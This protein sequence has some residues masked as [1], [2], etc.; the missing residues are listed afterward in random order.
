MYVACPKCDWRPEPV[1]RWECSCGYVW[2]T[3]ETGGICPVCACHWE[4][5]LCPECGCWS[6]HEDWYHFPYDLTVA[7]YLANP[8]LIKH[9]PAA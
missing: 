4:E 6:D 7:E 1:H 8:S 3:F 2:N 5:T 9:W